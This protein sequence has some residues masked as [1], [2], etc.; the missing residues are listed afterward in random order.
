MG[1]NLSVPEPSDPSPNLF[2]RGGLG[3]VVESLA[4]LELGVLDNA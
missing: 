2:L 4:A 1:I 3:K